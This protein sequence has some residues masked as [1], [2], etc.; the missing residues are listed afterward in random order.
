MKLATP[1]AILLDLDDTILAFESLKEECWSITADRYSSMLGGIAPGD[2]V[3]AVLKLSDWFW[4][5]AERG[6]AW[7]QDIGA[8]RIEILGMAMRELGIYR[9][10]ACREIGDFYSNLRTEKIEPVPGAIDTVKKFRD[11]GIRTALITNGSSE[12]QRQKIERFGLGEHF[13]Q[14]LIEGENGFGKPDERIYLKALHGLG[15]E[16]GDSWMIGD[17]IVWDVLAPQKLGIRGIWVDYRKQGFRSRN[18]RRPYFS[19]GSL[20]EILAHMDLQ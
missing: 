3:S 13:D 18:G 7:R 17:N 20:P 5:D 14:I 8:A 12:T 9:E 1:K 16:A 19:I 11:N 2:F 15:I 6:K 10:E 4:S